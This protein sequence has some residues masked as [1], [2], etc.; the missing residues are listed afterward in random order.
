MSPTGIP[1][2]SDVWVGRVHIICL[3]KYGRLP[4]RYAI[5]HNGYH[6]FRT[7]AAAR[8]FARSL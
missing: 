2:L 6:E 1:A 5:S 4:F 7:L 8:K 3:D